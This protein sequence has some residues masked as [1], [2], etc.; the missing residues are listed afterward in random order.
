MK[1][2]GIALVPAAGVGQRMGADIHK[3]FIELDDK[4]LLWHCLD[5][6]SNV[7]E[8]SNIVIALHQDDFNFWENHIDLQEGRKVWKP[9]TAVVGGATRTH[10]VYEAFKKA[11]EIN[12]NEF[13]ACVHDAARPYTGSET[14]R[15]V[16]KAAET[17]SVA[18]LALEVVDT[19]KRQHEDG[20]LETLERHKLK[21]IQTPQVILSSLFEEGYQKWF[22]ESCPQLT[23]DFQIVESIGVQVTLLAGDARNKK[24]TYYSDI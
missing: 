12:P 22:D 13:Y 14:I 16:L 7:P 17:T 11:K 5:Q 1:F 8:I 6:L 3:A 9:I 20:R 21:A 15:S 24:I 10:S 2:K 4:P 18:G 19:I 23:D